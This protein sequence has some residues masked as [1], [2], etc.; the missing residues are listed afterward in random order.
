[1]TGKSIWPILRGDA[2]RTALYAVVMGV[3]YVLLA[4]LCVEIPRAYGQAAPIWLPTAFAVACLLLSASRRWPVM[5]A[6][7]AIGG[8]AAG[9][10]AGDPG[11]VNVLLVGCNILQMFGC[12]WGVRRL[13][14][15]DIDLGR[16]RDLI[17]FAV[18]GG[19]GV[20]IVT[21]VLAASINTLLRGGE[22]LTTI[23]VW[24]LSDILGLL[25]LTPCL[26]ALARADRRPLSRDGL[27][28]L[29]VLLIVTV[30]VFAQ[31][32]YPLLFVIPPV[33][34][35]VAWRLEI[36]G[37]AIGATLVAAVALFFTMI[38][39][40]PIHLLHGGPQDRA[41][42]LQLFVAVAIFV[43]LPVASFQRHRRAILDRIAAANEAVARSEA[44]Y[45]LLAENG[46]DMIV[47]SD[48]RG[49]ITYI[50]PAVHAVAGYAI[51]ELIGR[52]VSDFVHPQD[53]EMLRA[54]V[55]TQLGAAPPA[56]TQPIEFRFQRKDRSYIWLESR[57]T[58]AR[59]PTTGEPTSVTDILRDV[60]LRKALEQDLRLAQADA[61][62]AAAV[63]GEFLANMSHELRTPLT[64]V[65]GFAG[66]V[67]R[68]P[69]LTPETRGHVR[70]VLNASKSLLATVSDI[71]DF[72]KL[73]AGQLELAR[74]PVAPTKLALEALELFALDAAAK[75]LTLAAEGL[76]SL[77]DRLLLDD[78]R[79]RQVLLNLIGNGVKFTEH[80]GVTLLA[81]YDLAGERLS[82]TIA[83]TGPGVAL[84]AQAQLF[85]RFSQVDAALNHKHGGSGLGLAIC[86]GLVE[87]MDGEIGVESRPG[88]GAR[89]SFHIA[90]PLAGPA[91]PN[92]K[93]AYAIL[94]PACR[95]LIADDNP[96]NRELVKAVLAA[97]NAQVEEAVDGE[98][99]VVAADAKLYDVILMDLR[100]PRLDGVG[101]AAR[102]RAG[103]GLN[104]A[105]PI[106]AFSADARPGAAGDPFDGAVHKPM[107]VDS[108]VTAISTAM[109]AA[110]HR[111]TVG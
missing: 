39:H 77:P 49:R 110:P 13:T 44:R 106:L 1:M 29:F 11:L 68:A 17:V 53:V 90:A 111:A 71:L 18:V 70:H 98:E 32:R 30:G 41:V 72:S 93:T 103:G 12:A 36:L 51:E 27:L 62:A 89:F 52:Q 7:T 9:V 8:L 80:G 83:D 94:R 64:S 25:T 73:E 43:S 97:M 50:S 15:R 46:L 57:P 14:G 45:R 4:Y 96:A 88:A 42:V 66:L 47:Q 3:G 85:R 16:P 75:N 20:P 81:A 33:M 55:A 58:A 67:D 84:E 59:D 79:L 92:P 95:V 76:D 48:P 60:T 2:V 21:G 78:D 101:A 26:L 37:A 107:T 86:K 6:V 40:G 91:A 104:A 56:P 23:W 10:Q 34:L 22:L 65:L 63:K 24:T 105:T 35:L 87:I 74:Q 19:L 100:M 31:N 28:A 82:F 54:A 69:E 109:D 5:L 108:L 38:G 61:E 99:A 102:I